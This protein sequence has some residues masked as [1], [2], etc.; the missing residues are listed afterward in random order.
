MKRGII[1]ISDSHIIMI[2][3]ESVWMTQFEIAD[4]FE[5]FSC[6]IRKAIHFIY[7]NDEADKAETMQYVKLPNGTSIDTYNIEIVI[8]VHFRIRS[9]NSSIFRKFIAENLKLKNH[10]T[11][12]RLSVF[13]NNSEERKNELSMN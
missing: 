10:S 12:I 2:P 5:V 3:S 7:K 11:A 6:D 1:T 4:L 8:A 13:F 9:K